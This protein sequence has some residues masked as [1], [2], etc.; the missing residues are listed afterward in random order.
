M[1]VAGDA[2]QRLAGMTNPLPGEKEKAASYFVEKNIEGSTGQPFIDSLEEARGVILAA[3][4]TTCP[5]LRTG[6]ARGPG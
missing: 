6:A 2:C 1:I 3:E 5:R 4:S